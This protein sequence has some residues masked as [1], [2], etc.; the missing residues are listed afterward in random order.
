MQIRETYIGY[1]WC[2]CQGFHRISL[3]IH[4]GY[5]TYIGRARHCAVRR[6][7]GSWNH[8]YRD[9]GEYKC[10]AVRRA[11][12]RVPFLLILSD[13]LVGPLPFAFVLPALCR[14][15]LGLTSTLVLRNGG[16]RVLRRYC[17]RPRCYIG[18][19]LSLP[20]C[21]ILCVETQVGPSA[22]LQGVRRGREPS[23]LHRQNEGR[24]AL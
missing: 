6:S 9:A 21:Y 4:G 11:L 20:R 12:R 2:V 24:G 8:F 22:D 1:S 5:E 15:V 16:R 23:R 13:L 3:E 14:I 7:A 19:S 18:C 17:A 10:P